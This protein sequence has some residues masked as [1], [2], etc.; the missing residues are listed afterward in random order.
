LAQ[1]S[2]LWIGK[3]L[4]RAHKVALRSFVHY[5]H[6]LKLYVYDMSLEV[7]P[8]VIK[9]DA[10]GIVPESEIFIHHG[11]LAPF[12]DYFRYKMIAKTGEMWVDADTICVSEYFFEDKEYVFIEEMPNFYA[13]GILKMPSD[14]NLCNFLN[15]RASVLMIDKNEN[16]N[17]N[18]D[19]WTTSDA[20]SWIF[21]GPG[22]LTE[23]VKTLSLEE[24]GQP[25]LS[26][27]GVDISVSRESP[28]ELLWYPKNKDLMLERI[29]SSISL[30]FFNSSMELNGWG[31][32]LNNLPEGS[33]MREFEK[34]FLK[35]SFNTNQPIG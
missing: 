23:A 8:G 21:L 33:L 20:K 10:N 19:T 15:K 13:Q 9:V 34:T 4:S 27:N 6:S 5:G 29:K 1:V 25:V 14:S 12:A 7:P 3:P 22:L 18:A 30:T 11:Q 32:H 2:S 28:Y 26:V 35:M 31:E 24:F 16:G 17:F